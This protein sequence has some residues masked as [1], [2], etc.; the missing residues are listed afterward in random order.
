MQMSKREKSP[1]LRI[2]QVCVVV[3]DLDKAVEYYEALGIGPFRSYDIMGVDR[4]VYGKPA[5][6][7]KNRVKYAQIGQVHFELLQPVSG[8]SLQAEF[9]ET[10]G[11]GIHHLGFFVDNI[12]K[13]TPKLLEKGLTLTET[14]RVVDRGGRS[15]SDGS[16]AIFNP[17]AGL[18]FELVQ[19][20]RGKSG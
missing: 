18:S 2:N 16:L 15:V 13:E 4:E 14:A 3:R 12:D 8:E 10:R 19:L 11:E 7:V 20:P 5:G 9:L 6:D 1:F 17:F